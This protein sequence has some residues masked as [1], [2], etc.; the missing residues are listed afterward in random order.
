MSEPSQQTISP[1]RNK[2]LELVKLFFQVIA[3]LCAEIFLGILI[4]LMALYG[5]DISSNSAFTTNVGVTAGI[6]GIPL[7]AITVLC[8]L[9]IGVIDLRDEALNEEDQLKEFQLVPDK[10]G[11]T[12]D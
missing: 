1:V 5:I 8:A 6:I 2:N 4:T 12:N 10:G 7:F 9:V 3:L 11:A